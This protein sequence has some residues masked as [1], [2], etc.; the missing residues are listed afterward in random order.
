MH[1]PT[2]SYQT[3]GKQYDTAN[4]HKA[5]SI[6][7][8][9]FTIEALSISVHAPVAQFATGKAA[10]NVASACCQEKG[11]NDGGILTLESSGWGRLT[12]IP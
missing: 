7:G 1:Q 9:R 3:G 5:Q 10:E 11:A 6:F 4:P 8:Q 2:S 12:V